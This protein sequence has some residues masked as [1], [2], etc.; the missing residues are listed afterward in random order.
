MPQTHGDLGAVAPVRLHNV[1]GASPIIIV[2]EHASN[3]MPPSFGD[4]GLDEEALTSHAAYDPGAGAVAE[5][6]SDRFDAPLVSGTMS[7]LIYDLNRPPEAPSAMTERSERFDIPGNHNLTDAEK[8]ARIAQI[9]RPFERA[10]ADLMD[11]RQDGVLVTVH[12]FAPIYHGKP[13]SVELGIVHDTDR[14][15]ADVM[16]ELAP[17]MRMQGLG[18]ERNAPYG[19]QDGVTHT[20]KRHAIPRRWLN[21][22]LEIRNDLI[23]TAADQD[24]VAGLLHVLI[25]RAVHRL[26]TAP[27]QRG[28]S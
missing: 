9:Y 3:H 23:A 17:D 10:L 8:A 16:L 21:V 12:S 2:C 25:D 22:M 14:R 15:L 28:R 4:L 13:R 7:R 18:A 1:Q 27:S 20:L 19:P 6:L 5:R 26:R 24:R 11:G